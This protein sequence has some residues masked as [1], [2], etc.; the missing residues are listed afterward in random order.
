MQNPLPGVPLIDN[1]FFD[2]LFPALNADAETKRIALDLRDKGFAVLD[3]PDAEIGRLAEEIKTRHAPS[4]EKLAA[5]RA[6]GA[7]LRKQDG[8]RED[9]NVKRVA[10]NA[11]ILQILET[12]YG[13]PAFAFQ[14]LNF[15]VGSQQPPH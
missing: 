3:F 10:V 12:I 1:P 6:G 14:T 4:Q 9:P 11:R 8:W 13:R 15:A 7:E 2:R 5:W